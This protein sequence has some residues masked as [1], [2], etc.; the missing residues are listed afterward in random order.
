M[1]Y[2]A[3]VEFVEGPRQAI[4]NHG[5]LHFRLVLFSKKPFRKRFSNCLS[6]TLNEYPKCIDCADLRGLWRYC[7]YHTYNPFFFISG[8]K[9]GIY[10]EKSKFWSGFL[11]QLASPREVNPR[12]INR[13]GRVGGI[14]S[15]IT[16]DI[17]LFY[18]ILYYV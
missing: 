13:K 10:F 6:L 16:S 1:A 9:I 15:I 7:C 11:L 5:L 17:K 3:R 2:I 14:T 18:T 8:A 4:F 12:G